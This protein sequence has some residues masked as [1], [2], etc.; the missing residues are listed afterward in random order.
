[1]TYVHPKSTQNRNVIYFNDVIDVGFSY[2][3][4]RWIFGWLIAL[5][6]YVA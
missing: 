4:E 1:M 2:A 3:L 6:I 5:R